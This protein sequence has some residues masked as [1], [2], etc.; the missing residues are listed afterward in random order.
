MYCRDRIGQL[1]M[2]GIPHP[3]LDSATRSLLKDLHP[4]GIILFRRNYTD[5][6]TLSHLCAELHSLSSEHP[7]LIA[8]DH[9]GGRVH[10]LAPPFTHFPPARLLGQAGTVA[11]AHQTGFAMGCELRAV[12][13]DINFAPVLDVQTNAANTVIGD[14]AFAADPYRVALLGCAVARG[15][16]EAG[17]IPCGKHFPG[18]GATLI[19]SHDDLPRDE[20]TKDEIERIDLYPFRCAIAEQLEMVMTA[21]V[22]YPALDPTFPATLSSTI[23]NGLLR[24]TLNFPGVVVSDDL[25]MGAIARHTTIVQAALAA[26]KAGVDLL[27]ICHHPE[28]ALVVREACLTALHKGELSPQR[29]TEAAERLLALKRHHRTHQAQPSHRPIGAAEHRQLVAAIRRQARRAD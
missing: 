17:V 6:D 13:I 26:L 11:L 27:L 23:I 18:H 14:R 4:G 21:H 16:R 19:D 28:L 12:G 8:L 15:L 29:L 9:E 22:L 3:A 1:F 24:Q 10:R 25:E 5:P 2:V 7:P 20:R